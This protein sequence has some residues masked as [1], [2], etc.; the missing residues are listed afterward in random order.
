MIETPI[1][2][3]PTP[4]P[5]P[6]TIID[7]VNNPKEWT[8]FTFAADADL[9]TIVFP[10]IRDCDSELLICNGET[11]LIDCGSHEFEES[12]VAMLKELGIR[13]IDRLL[14][15][16]P[17]HDHYEGLA[18]IAQ[19]IHIG[20]LM[21]SFPDD[22]N[23]HMPLINEWTSLFGIP[24]TRYGDGDVLTLGG[25]TLTVY[26][27][28][29]ENYSCNNRSAVLLLRY[30]ERTMLFGSDIEIAGMKAMAATTKEGEIRVDILKYP[31]HG[32]AALEWT[33]AKAITPQ[34]CIITNKER[35]WDGQ[36]WLYQNRIPYINTRI[37]GVVLT[38]DGERWLA[39]NFYAEDD[40]RGR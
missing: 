31:H 23:E 22:Y 40:P 7:R 14:I 8:D 26:D 1:P 30:G 9:L 32:K 11:L 24:V 4:V 13:S 29:P 20:E 21:I 37:R 5:T 36:V 28:C 12:I 17:H 38:T 6:P 2:A 19:Y 35:G 15:T 10:P 3:T 39:E 18:Y 33:F 27:R 34:L 25:A 16:H